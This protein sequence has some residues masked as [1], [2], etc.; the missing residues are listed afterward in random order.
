MNEDLINAIWHKDDR[1]TENQ[2]LSDYFNGF[3]LYLRLYKTGYKLVVAM[4][5]YNK[6]GIND[7]LTS[8]TPVAYYKNCT[9]EQAKIKAVEHFQWMIS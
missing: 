1:N 7:N 5:R 9:M 2:I 4:R 3:R 8:G 6:H